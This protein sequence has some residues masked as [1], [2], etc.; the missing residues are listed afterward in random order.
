MIW[1]LTVQWFVDQW[2]VN[3]L[4]PGKRLFWGYLLSALVIG[5]IWLVVVQ[6]QQPRAGIKAL[7]SKSVWLSESARADYLIFTLNSILM[8]AIV[9]RLLGSAAVA[10]VLFELLHDAFGG[11]AMIVHQ[12]PSWVIATSFTFTFFVLDDLMRYFVHRLMHR[13]PFLWAF[14]KV[15]HSAT[16][17]N[18]LTVLRT[19]PIEG[20]IFILRG[21]L[22]Q[23]FCIAT[24]VFFFGSSVSLLMVMGANVFKFGFN[25]LGSNLRHSEIPL[26][27]WRWLEK[28]FLS[29]AQHQIHHSIDPR[30]YDKNFGVTLA[31]WDVLFRSHYHSESNQILK[32]GVHNQTSQLQ[33]THSIASL[34]FVPIK[35]AVGIL[36]RQKSRQNSA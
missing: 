30:H 19:H 28:L 14:H 33:K 22:V 29:P 1:E 5:L 15:H 32:Y 2:A 21:A 8:S 4:D 27:Y 12:M 25:A 23:G 10:Y 18:P 26:R 36:F 35:E 17:L 11:R 7:F 13:I 24:F 20:V 6:R 34:Y 16:S 9:P 31:I 3:F